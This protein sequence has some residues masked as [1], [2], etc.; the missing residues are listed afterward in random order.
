MVL[1]KHWELAGTRPALLEIMETFEKQVAEII[2]RGSIINRITAGST[3]AKNGELEK[4][5]TMSLRVANALYA[6]GRKTGNEPLKA[7]CRVTVSDIGR[8]REGEA[9]QFCLRTGELARA[10][11]EALA[12]YGITAEDLEELATTAE[13]YRELADEKSRNFTEAKALREGLGEMF[14][15]TRDLLKEDMD[16]LM[17]MFRD[18]NP[19]FYRQYKAAR[20]IHDLGGGHSSKSDKPEADGTDEPVPVAVAGS[21]G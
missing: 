17:E 11:A 18:E 21:E 3:I 4:L 19:D 7:E 13:K 2:E 12:G 9:E 10:N 1:K 20:I 14:A 5:T 8:L 15:T 6:I 16:K